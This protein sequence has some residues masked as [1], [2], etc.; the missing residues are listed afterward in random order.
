MQ[1][2]PLHLEPGPIAREWTVVHLKDKLLTDEIR[3]SILLQSKLSE[4][5]KSVVE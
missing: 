3:E 4:L 5:T 1:Q 2:R